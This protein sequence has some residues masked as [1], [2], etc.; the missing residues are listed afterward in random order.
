MRLASRKFTE[1]ASVHD[2][3]AMR[4]ADDAELVRVAQAGDAT[5]LGMLLE[6]HRARLHAI[7]VGLLGHGADADDAVQDTFVIALRRIGELREP[8]AAGGWLAAILVNRCRARLRR[9]ARERLTGDPVEPLG[10]L[11]TVQESVERAALRDWVWTA[12]EHL[13]EPQRVAVM[14]RHFSSASSYAAIADLCGV[15]VGTVRSRLNAA[16]A[17][18]ADELLSLAAEAHADR[19][20]PETWAAAT[21]AAMTA[22]ERS[23]DRRLLDS[24]FTPDLRFRMADRVE[25]HG[26]DDFA[27]RLAG[28]FDDGVT[29]KPLRAIAG[30]HV[31]IIELV[32][33]SPPEQPLH[34]PPAVTQ[35]HYHDAGRTHR[36]VSHYAHR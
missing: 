28:D 22:F 32:L 4:T 14:L 13:P 12:L 33:D 36:L 1:L 10:A 6:R 24:V 20:A 19:D 26:R 21:G 31:T 27:T 23:G 34:C 2:N 5:A 9:P 7:A 18:L 30:E 11:D 25:R 8:G 35:V 16:R 15:P 17:R 3:D 29:A